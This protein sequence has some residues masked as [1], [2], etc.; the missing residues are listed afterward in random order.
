MVDEMAAGE[1]QSRS[2]KFGVGQVQHLHV[3]A[4]AKSVGLN[5]AY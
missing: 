3:L 2:A 5:L 1:V 4:F